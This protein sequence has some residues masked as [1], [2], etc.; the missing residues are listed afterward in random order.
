MSTTEAYAGIDIGGT[1]IKFGLFD[2]KGKVLYRE[3]RPTL[4]EKGPTPLMH[5]V[6]NIG[7]RLLY[8]AA[9]EDYT[10]RWLGVGTPGAVDFKTGKVIG[11]CPNIDGW[12][13]MEIGRILRER[14]NIPVWVDND[15]NAVALAEMRFGAAVGAT[16]VVCVTVGTGV[17][18]A[19]I[20][21]G[22]L[23][24]GAT[25]SAGELGHMSIN[26]DAPI[27]HAGIPGSI[28]AYCS[29]YSILEQVKSKLIH[30]LSPIFQEVLEGD[31]EKLV[32]KKVFIAAKKGDEIARAVLNETAK[33]LGIG[34]A[35]VVNLLN[36]EIVVIGGGI[37]EGG[38]GFI[39]A[40]TAELKTYAFDSAVEKLM[41]VKAAL[42]NDAGFI[43]AGLL[44][45]MG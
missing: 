30:G 12:Q 21:D 23:W 37:A 38:A 6:G 7:E 34:L 15:V 13:G 27:A 2:Q 8:H 32:I 20:I 43:G 45:E 14:L 39:E 33:Y 41:V 10:V 16:S 26:F 40:V 9:E 31:L 35:G 42:G 19:V 4:A 5:L 22:K 36:P 17:G 24:R 11:P 44:G 1:N 25:H 29:S 28:E 18:G 3:Q